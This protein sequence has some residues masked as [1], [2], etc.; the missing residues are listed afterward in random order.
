MKSGGGPGGIRTHTFCNLNAVPLPIGV[1]AH[2]WFALVMANRYR[3]VFSR[4]RAYL[5]THGVRFSATA[6]RH[7]N[8]KPFGAP[9]RT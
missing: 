9:C 8:H 6:N 1:L 2:G 5:V 7:G 4:A 3:L